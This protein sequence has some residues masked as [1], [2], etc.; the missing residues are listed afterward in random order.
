MR[1]GGGGSRSHSHNRV[2]VDEGS[3]ADDIV[4]DLG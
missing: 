3:M 1:G 2:S 4:E